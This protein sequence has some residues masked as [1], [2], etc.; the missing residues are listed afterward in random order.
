MELSLSVRVVESFSDKTRATM[1]FEELVRLAQEIGYSAVCMRA[2]QA[3]AHTPPERLREMRGTLDGLGLAA[4]MVTGDFAIPQNNE[5][6]PEALRNITPHLDVA[7]AFGATLIR[8]CMKQ[9]EDIAFAQQAADE[10]RERGIR[11]AH[12]CHTASLFETVEGALETL[13]RVG[14]PNFGL[15]YEPA[16]LDLCGQDYGPET[17]RQFAPYLFNVYVQNHRRH[18]GGQ[19]AVQTWVGGEVRFDQ[20]RLQDEGGID[21]PRAFE[22]LRA[23]GYDGYVTVHQAFAG[24]LGAEAAARQSYAYLR[25]LTM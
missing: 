17:L 2:S 5:R 21:F 15:I 3:G 9:A 12:Q 18:A 8:I 13:R 4:S 23:V 7:E 11:L 25:S 19:A 6:G 20:I 22:G 16:N 1:G 10:A 24:L 14:R